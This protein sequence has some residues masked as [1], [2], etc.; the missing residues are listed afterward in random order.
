MSGTALTFVEV[1]RYQQDWM[2]A[3]PFEVIK[4]ESAELEKTVRPKTFRFIMDELPRRTR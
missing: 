1:R 3:P 2:G 4:A